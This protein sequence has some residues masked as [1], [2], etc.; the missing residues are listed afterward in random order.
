M[1]IDEYLGAKLRIAARGEIFIPSSI[2]SFF[3]EQ[4]QRDLAII[5]KYE[6]RKNITS[7]SSK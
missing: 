3:N 4:N 5:R 7:I 6:T 1:Y 2:Q